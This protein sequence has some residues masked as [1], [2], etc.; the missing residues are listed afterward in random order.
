ME[1]RDLVKTLFEEAGTPVVGFVDR[2]KSTYS[3]FKT[4]DMVIVKVGNEEKKIALD[5]T[6][7]FICSKKACDHE[8]ET[9]QVDLSDPNSLEII[10]GWIPWLESR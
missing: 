6:T 2:N 9:H 5:G 4:W 1:I 10:K 7:L 8:G 3:S